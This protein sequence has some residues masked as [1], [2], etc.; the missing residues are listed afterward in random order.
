ML[1]TEALRSIYDRY[2]EHV[3]KNG[4]P[5]KSIFS[6]SHFKL[7]DQTHYGYSFNGDPME[8][9]ESFFGTSNPFHIEVDV[10]GQQIPLV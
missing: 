9:F 5:G 3:L 6:L 8:I 10:K 2:G 7:T 4:T 1:S